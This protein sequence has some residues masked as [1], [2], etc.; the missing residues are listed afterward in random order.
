MKAGTLRALAVAAPAR[1]EALSDVPTLAEAGYN[2]ESDLW[3][4][5]V[6]PAETPKAVVA[7]TAGWFTSALE[8]PETKRKLGVQ[9][10]FP[11]VTCGA[12]FG[13]I[14]RKQYDEYGRVIRESNIK[15]E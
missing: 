1:I 6:A 13:A 9:M 14:I 10:L 5:G 12:D 7:E 2:V 3:N 11:F 4:G 8:D 15:A